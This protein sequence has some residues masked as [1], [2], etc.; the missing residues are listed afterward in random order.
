MLGLASGGPFMAAEVPL[1]AATTVSVGLT[2]QHLDHDR[3][4]F[5]SDAER[6]AYAGI[7]ALEANAINLRMTHRATSNL[8]FNASWAHVRERNSLLGVQSRE[9][10]DLAHGAVTDTL[11]LASTLKLRQGLTLAVSATAGRTNTSGAPEQGFTTADSVLSSAFA[12][13]ATWQGVVGRRDALRLSVSQPF[14]VERGQLAYDSVQVVDRATG[15]LGVVDQRFD[16]GGTPRAFTGELLYAAPILDDAGEIGLFGR[17]DFSGEN[18]GEVNQ[19]AVGGRI[20][21]RF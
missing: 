9:R 15:E 12:A 6:A 11:T 7:D 5:L 3:V 16:I 8:T 4:P 17:A 20:N 2:E 18:Q 21:V 13:S 10:T 14:H 1:G 19:F